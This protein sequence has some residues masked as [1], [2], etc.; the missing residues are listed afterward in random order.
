MIATLKKL[1]DELE[2]CDIQILMNMESA[3]FRNLDANLKTRLRLIEK[4]QSQLN[5]IDVE[6]DSHTNIDA[7][8]LKAWHQKAISR[9]KKVLSILRP[10]RDQSKADLLKCSHVAPQHPYRKSQPKTRISV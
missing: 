2:A 6:S 4:I 8:T 7:E 5:L 3:L 10:L 1:Y 9:D